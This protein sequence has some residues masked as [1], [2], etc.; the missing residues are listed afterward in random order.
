VSGPVW[1]DEECWTSEVQIVGGH[2]VVLTVHGGSE[3]EV[4][5]RRDACLATLAA[6]RDGG[7]K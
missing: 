7:A 2:E 5:A 6:L 4:V 3:Q 1:Q